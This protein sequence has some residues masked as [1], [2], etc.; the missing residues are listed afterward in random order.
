MVLCSTSRL[1]LYGSGSFLSSRCC[2]T[3]LLSTAAA[4][5]RQAAK[6]SLGQAVKKVRKQ[7]KK[8]APPTRTTV[9]LSSCATQEKFKKKGLCA[10]EPRLFR[11]VAWHRSRRGWVGQ[12]LDKQGKQ[13]TVG[14]VC[15]SQLGAAKLVMA[16][17]NARDKVQPAWTIKDLTLKAPETGK[18][19]VAA[20]TTQLCFPGHQQSGYMH[21]YW[22]PSCRL[23][24]ARCNKTCLGYYPDQTAAATEVGRDIISELRD[25]QDNEGS[26]MRH[27]AQNNSND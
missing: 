9:E 14:H 16:Y 17:L 22:R 24:E 1:Q 2:I 11:Y 4:M 12:C 8:Q 13:V 5:G 3:E 27:N 26:G 23:W 19:S 15:R 20:R 18:R 6:H 7:T 10:P 25:G 21:V